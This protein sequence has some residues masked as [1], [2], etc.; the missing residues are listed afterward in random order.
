M[1]VSSAAGLGNASGVS[2]PVR[3][4][5][6]SPR[7]PTRSSQRARIVAG[8][9]LHVDVELGAERRLPASRC[10]QVSAVCI[11]WC[12]RRPCDRAASRLNTATAIAIFV[13][14]VPDDRAQPHNL[15]PVGRVASTCSELTQ[16][17]GGQ[18]EAPQHPGIRPR[19]RRDV[20]GHG[21]GHRQPRRRKQAGVIHRPA[22]EHRAMRCRT[23]ASCPTIRQAPI[24][25]SN[26]SDV[27]D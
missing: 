9:H 23:G 1:N 7:S 10:L 11:R 3:T 8:G 21:V 19:T 15:G 26:T 17:R 16:S 27:A 5:A 6:F 25:M 14:T 22:R 18:H 12:R 13:R 2:P 20:L 4:L 24:N